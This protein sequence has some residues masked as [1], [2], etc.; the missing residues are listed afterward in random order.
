MER[1]K[2]SINDNDWYLRV[3]KTPEEREK[4]LQNVKKL[5]KNEE[6]YCEICYG[7]LIWKQRSICSAMLR[8]KVIYTDEFTV[9]MTPM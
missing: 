8:R 4:G 1:V 3:A 7:D 6:R 5:G 2:V 9:S